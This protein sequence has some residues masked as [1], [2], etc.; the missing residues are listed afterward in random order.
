MKSCPD[1]FFKKEVIAMHVVNQDLVVLE[2]GV[3]S[4]VVQACC[5]SNT[6]KL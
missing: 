1:I 2:E 4:G 3:E 6:A 5:T